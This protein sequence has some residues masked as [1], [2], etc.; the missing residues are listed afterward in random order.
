VERKFFFRVKAG[1]EEKVKE[2]FADASEVKL[3]G[4]AEET[5]FVTGVMTEKDFADKYAKL[6][7]AVTGTRIRMEA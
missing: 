4:V 6:G 3:A 7:D 5:G 2:L 1:N